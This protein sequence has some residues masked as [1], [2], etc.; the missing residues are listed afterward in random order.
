[1]IEPEV[2]ARMNAMEGLLYPGEGA[3]LASL[4]ATVPADQR[5][6]EIGSYWGLSTCWL[7][8]GARCG[9]GAHVVA[10]D[11][12]SPEG[13][14][15]SD[16]QG[17]GEHTLDRFKVNITAEGLWDRISAFRI[18]SPEAAAPWVNPVGMVFI[19]GR[20]GLWDVM[21]DANAWAPKVEVGGCI[22]FH[23]YYDDEA[24]THP[25]Q[26]AEAIED[27]VVAMGC[28]DVLP[29]VAN[30]WSARRV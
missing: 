21:A 19:D 10:F 29:M 14:E 11:P 28:W 16:G 12:W 1:M 27:V 5:I 20:H 8:H 15:V 6:V 30:T 2:L 25:S 9:A 23:D 3:Y 13:V 17:V 4:A 24:W 22:A 26:V 18:G 7:A